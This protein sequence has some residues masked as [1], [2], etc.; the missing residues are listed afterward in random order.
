MDDRLNEV[1]CTLAE[2]TGISMEEAAERISR[3][4]QEVVQSVKDL[5]DGLIRIFEQIEESGVFDIESR[6]RRRKRD[7]DRARLIEQRYNAE[8]RRCERARPFR[9]VYKPP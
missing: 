1:V 6:H 2:R 7:R 5:C 8:I 9:R 4:I 3:A